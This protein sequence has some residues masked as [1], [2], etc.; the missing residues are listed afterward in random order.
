MIENKAHQFLER[1]REIEEWVSDNLNIQDM[2]D[3]E[4][5]PRY[6]N[7]RSNLAFCR[8]LR[9][10]LSHYDWS[11]AGNDLVI[12]TDGALQKVNSLYYS[13]NQ[14]TLMR[15]ATP[16]SRI[17]SPAW[18]DS[19][20]SAIKVMT[21]NDYSYVPISNGQNVEGV[22][23]AKVVMYYLAEQ[24]KK[25]IDESLTF[26]DLRPYLSEQQDRW[27]KYDFIGSDATIEDASHKFQAT[28]DRKHRPD[29]LFITDN[30][31]A[32]GK[33]LAMITPQD[34]VGV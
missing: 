17:Y 28:R 5:M 3:L 25:F 9:N 6:H 30:G 8:Y 18:S 21:N 12:V 10:L 19:V 29:V 14:Q 2:R 4:Q 32:D 24:S 11:K 7:L 23:S 27:Q 33:L 1:Y 15:L 13:L 16:K 22:F 31:K 34:I 20:L 26:Q